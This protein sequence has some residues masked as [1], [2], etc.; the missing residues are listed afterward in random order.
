MDTLPDFIAD[1]VSILSIGINPSPH[2]IRAGY[3]FAFSGNRFWQALNASKLIQGELTPC[4]EAMYTLAD[5][6]GI[7][8]TDI[9][10]RPTPGL[11]DL[12]AA[13]FDSGALVLA[14]KIKRF[15][16]QILWFQGKSAAQ[17]FVKRTTESSLNLVLGLQPTTLCGCYCFISPNP[18]SA[19]ARYSLKDITTGYDELAKFWNSISRV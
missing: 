5:C 8:F 2:A 11:R 12:C 15:A 6:Y 10:K 19:N 17:A 4:V 16:P 7:G 18:S 1:P 14:E 3:P 13:D 9:V